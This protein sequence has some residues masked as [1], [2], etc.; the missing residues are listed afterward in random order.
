MLFLAVLEVS[1]NTE[2]RCSERVWWLFGRPCN[3]NGRGREERRETMHS[4]LQ[5]SVSNVPH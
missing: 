2:Y 5:R 1:A 4:K 3:E